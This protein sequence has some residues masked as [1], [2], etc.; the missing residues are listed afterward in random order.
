M[1]SFLMLILLILALK[2]IT[3]F[4]FYKLAQTYADHGFEPTAVLVGP[5]RLDPPAF[6]LYVS[7]KHVLYYKKLLSIDDQKM[8]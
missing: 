4:L 2:L 5:K 1:N 7:E 8:N 6:V 3:S